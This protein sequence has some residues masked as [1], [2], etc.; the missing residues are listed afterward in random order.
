MLLKRSKKNTKCVSAANEELT[1]A[2]HKLMLLAKVKAVQ[3]AAAGAHT[4]HE[5]LNG[6]LVTVTAVP[7]IS[8]G[9]PR[10]TLRYLSFYGEGDALAKDGWSL[11]ERCRREVGEGLGKHATMTK[12]GMECDLVICGEW[13]KVVEGKGGNGGVCVEACVTR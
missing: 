9:R 13:I 5:V 4:N 6:Q 10:L 2:K 3:D 8:G 11:K 1:A 12:A 7:D